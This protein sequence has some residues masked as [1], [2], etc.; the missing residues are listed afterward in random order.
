[1]PEPKAIVAVGDGAVNGC[2]P[3]QQNY[4]IFKTGKVEDVIPVD[5]NVLGNPLK[6]L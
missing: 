2:S 3:N 4:A 6:P 5:V 1:M